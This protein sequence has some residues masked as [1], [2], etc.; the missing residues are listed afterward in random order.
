MISSCMLPRTTCDDGSCPKNIGNIMKSS[1]HVPQDSDGRW[2]CF[3][4][5]LFHIFCV[6]LCFAGLYILRSIYFRLR[7]EQKIE[8]ATSL[9]FPLLL[10]LGFILGGLFLVCL[11]QIVFFGFQGYLHLV[12]GYPSCV[13]LGVFLFRSWFLFAIRIIFRSNCLYTLSRQDFT[14]NN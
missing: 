8:L 3:F 10:V 6:P 13:R 7:R 12:V 4:L 14:T 1:R 9:C 5:L 2:C 11:T